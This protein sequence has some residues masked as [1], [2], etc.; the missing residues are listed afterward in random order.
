MG[1]LKVFKKPSAK[2]LGLPS[3]SFTMDRD[4]ELVVRTV[5]SSF[6]QALIEQIGQLVLEVFREA[7]AAQIALSQITISY[8]SFKITARELRGGTMVFLIPKDTLAPETH[9]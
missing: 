9:K 2:L 8:P 4:G 6:P 1:L 7:N 5:P 3:G